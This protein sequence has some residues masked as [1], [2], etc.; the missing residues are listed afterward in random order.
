MSETTLTEEQA[1]AVLDSVLAC[2]AREPSVTR[3]RLRIRER[4]D[5]QLDEVRQLA[6]LVRACRESATLADAF[7]DAG[8]DGL[9]DLDLRAVTPRTGVLV[10]AFNRFVE[11]RW[12]EE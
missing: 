12:E 5:D 6:E 7:R 11:E 8:L 3:T 10:Q 4:G 1:F 2:F 9:A